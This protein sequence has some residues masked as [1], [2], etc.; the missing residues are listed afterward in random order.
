MA[1]RSRPPRS[2]PNVPPEGYSNL[3]K[4]GLKFN[5]GSFRCEIMS[6][7]FLAYDFWRNYMHIHTFYE[8]CYAFEGAGTFEMMGQLFH[9]KPGEVFV[10]KPREEHEIISSRKNPLGI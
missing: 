3:N 1:A 5:V 9:I 6:W 10:A 4:M 7:G 8:I 2:V